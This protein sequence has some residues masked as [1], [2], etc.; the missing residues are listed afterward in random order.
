MVG[1]P[2][3]LALAMSGSK[4]SPSSDALTDGQL[5][6]AANRG[7]RS[8]FGQ[9][10][11]RHRD[12]A[13]RIAMRFSDDE[14][15]ALDAVQNAFVYLAGKLPT[16]VL[17]AKLSTF[18]YPVIKHEAMGIRR[19]KLRSHLASDAPGAGGSGDGR[20]A[21]EGAGTFD[22]VAARPA[23]KNASA[24]AARVARAVA[25]LTSM[26]REVILMRFVDDLS[27]EEISVVLGLPLGTVKSRLHHAL[28]RLQEDPQAVAMLEGK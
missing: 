3:H 26:H 24:A 11:Q 15:D 27:L 10:Y 4:R 14:G 28:K 23:P 1:P 2:N 25:G 20:D 5:V 12:F 6:D 17:T 18:L 19:R 8:A 9:L 22:H 13:L 16:L 21:G 7:D